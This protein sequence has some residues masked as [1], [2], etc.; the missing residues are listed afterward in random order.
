MQDSFFYSGRLLGSIFFSIIMSELETK[1][2]SRV[3][4]ARTVLAATRQ[5]LSALTVLLPKLSFKM[6]SANP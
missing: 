5:V 2:G 4:A 6:R 1:A 3:P